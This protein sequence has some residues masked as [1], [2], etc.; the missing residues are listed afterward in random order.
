MFVPSYH[1]KSNGIPILSKEEIDEI[2]NR[3]V[4]DYQPDVLTNPQ[5]V[6]IDL[7]VEL[8][9]GRPT[10]Y[11]YLSHNGIYLG[12]TVFRDT[13]KVV[14]YSPET[15]KAEYISAK[16]GTVIIDSRLLEA[17]KQRRCRFTLGHEAGHCILHSRYF[18]IKANKTDDSKPMIQ[19][20]LD[21]LMAGIWRRYLQSDHDWMEWQANRFA[22]AVLMPKKAVAIFAQS[23]NW[24]STTNM[25]RLG[26]IDNMAICFN[27]SEQASEYRLKE[28]GYLNNAYLIKL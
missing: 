28:L 5:P 26:M 20:R 15:N 22:S 14:I 16:A 11:Q 7:F 3:F 18:Q 2:A 1:E 13:N 19:C 24:R 12:M 9:L 8:Y 10:D 4:E 25:D 6:D 23:Y 27:V 17:K 21:N